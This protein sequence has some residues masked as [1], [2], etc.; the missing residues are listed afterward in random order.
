[1]IVPYAVPPRRKFLIVFLSSLGL[2]SCS[3]F[4]SPG[5]VAFQLRPSAGYAI[6][7]QRGFARPVAA[8]DVTVF[9]RT[10]PQEWNRVQDAGTVEQ[11]V[12]DFNAN[13]DRWREMPSYQR[14][15]LWGPPPEPPL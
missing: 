7:L 1:M 13:P 6:D 2:A 5:R 14:Q 4:D 15:I 11:L 9:Y 10:A 12:L 8:G 3:F